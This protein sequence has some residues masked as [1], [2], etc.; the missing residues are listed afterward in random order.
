MWNIKDHLFFLLD[1]HDD[2][3][4]FSIVYCIMM[5]EAYDPSFQRSRNKP[6]GRQLQLV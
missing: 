6:P 3:P 1:H 2:L 4:R 5:K